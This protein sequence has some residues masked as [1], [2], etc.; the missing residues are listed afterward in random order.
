MR[1]CVPPRLQT[2]T[3][4]A[5]ARAESHRFA[6]KK[7]RDRDALFALKLDFEELQPGLLSTG[8]K[9]SLIFDLNLAWLRKMGR[10]EINGMDKSH[11][12]H[13]QLLSIES[14]ERPGPRLKSPPAIE[15]LRRTPPRKIHAPVFA[16]QNRRKCRKRVIL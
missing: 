13:N 6:A 10:L 12:M 7:L 11:A 14:G 15:E 1:L 8:N 16:I 5:Q 2:L 4:C 9:Q 3:S